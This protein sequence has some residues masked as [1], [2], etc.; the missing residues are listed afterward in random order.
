MSE[1]TLSQDS[2]KQ[3]LKEALVEAL[4]E[5][6]QLLHEVF[7]EVLEDIALAGAIREGRSTKL[8]PRDQM[9]GVLKDSA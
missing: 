1:V 4:R 9:T 3:M 8:I 7:A 5:E 6:R 2:L